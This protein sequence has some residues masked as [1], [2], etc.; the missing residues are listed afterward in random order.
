MDAH[1]LTHQYQTQLVDALVARIAA[2]EEAVGTVFAF[3]IRRRSATTLVVAHHWP[4]VPQHVP[5]HRMYNYAGLEEA[6]DAL[7]DYCVMRQLDAIVETTIA[8]EPAT[9]HLLDQRQSSPHWSI[10]WLHLDLAQQSPYSYPHL[11]IRK[12]AARVYARV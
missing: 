4:D 3:D 6:D 7:L 11:S 5:F 9:K 1:G 12:V 10:P 2:T 8:P